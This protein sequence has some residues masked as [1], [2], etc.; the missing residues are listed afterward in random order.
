MFRIPPRAPTAPRSTV[1]RPGCVKERVA[2]LLGQMTLEEK[3]GQ[4]NHVGRA[5]R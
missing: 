3:V 5:A 1:T 4:L 2:D